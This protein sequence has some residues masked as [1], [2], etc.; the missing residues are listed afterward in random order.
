MKCMNNEEHGNTFTITQTTEYYFYMES[1]SLM[2]S[3]EPITESCL[4]YYCC[5]AEAAEAEQQQIEQEL[6]YL[7]SWENILEFI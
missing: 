6:D 1:L 7:N 5:T 4:Q 3:A 2:P